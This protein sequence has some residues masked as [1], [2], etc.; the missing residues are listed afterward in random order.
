MARPAQISDEMVQKAQELV[1]QAKTARDLWAGLSVLIPKQC[2]A[3]NRT[4]SAILGVS[5]ATV[6]RMQREIRNQASGTAQVK[7]SWG[8][9]RR[10]LLSPEEEKAFL[11]P[12]V[13]AAESGGVL[14]VPP[15]KAALEEKL[16]RSVPASTVY[17]LL[18]RHSWRKV[19]PDTCHPKRDTEEQDAFK[20][21]SRRY[22]WKQ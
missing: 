7:K 17:R 8:G 2:E 13:R 14:V 16:G 1:R 9:R 15:I 5:V 11:D 19:P 12:W 3:T 6:V 4:T 21:T 18:A 20:K 22:W 10:Q